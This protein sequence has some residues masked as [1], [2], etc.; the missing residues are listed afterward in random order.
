MIPKEA[1]CLTQFFF[2]GPGRDENNPYGY[3]ATPETA[4]K[5]QVTSWIQRLTSTLSRN[6]HD[7]DARDL[8]SQICMVLMQR[9]KAWKDLPPPKPYWKR[10][11]P[12]PPSDEEMS[13]AVSAIIEVLDSR[14]LILLA[15]DSGLDKATESLEPIGAALLRYDLKSIL[16]K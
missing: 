10:Q 1:S 12:Q 6:P 9:M 8:L 16:P 3:Y 2:P 13:L 14:E 7:E 15:V 11:P 5:P 4:Y